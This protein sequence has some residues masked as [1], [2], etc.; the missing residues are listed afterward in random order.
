MNTHTRLP[1]LDFPYYSGE[2]EGPAARVEEVKGV[3]IMRD[4]ELNL[5]D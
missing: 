5:E 3:G 4:K 1:S 2:S